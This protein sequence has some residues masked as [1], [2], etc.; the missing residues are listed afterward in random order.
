VAVA[1]RD[2]SESAPENPP[3]NYWSFQLWQPG[4]RQNSRN[5]VH[6][7]DNRLR[8]HR[9]CPELMLDEFA[10]AR[11]SDSSSISKGWS[12]RRW[13]ARRRTIE[14]SRP[15]MLIEKIK[16]RP[17][18]LTRWLEARG[19][20]LIEAGITFWPF[21]TSTKNACGDQTAAKH[22][23]RLRVAGRQ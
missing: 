19:Y 6:W 14:A 20:E 12:W 17:T 2:F 21:H 15:I 10:D 7:P 8:K 5:E 23:R 13:R 3:P 16:C 9:Q 4:L 1:R 18:Q 11:R 22:Q